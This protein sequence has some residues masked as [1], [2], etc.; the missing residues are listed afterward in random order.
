M[1][2]VFLDFKPRFDKRFATICFI[3]SNDDVIFLHPK[4][5]LSFITHTHTH[6]RVSLNSINI[7]FAACLFTQISSFYFS[8]WC[9]L[10]LI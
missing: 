7:Y 10:G 3:L 8:F 6:T 1:T 9:R 4:S 2:R 5:L